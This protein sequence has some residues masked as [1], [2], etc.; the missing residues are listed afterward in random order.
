V[1]VPADCSVTGFDGIEPPLGHAQVTSV[2]V[3]TEEIGESAVAR[4]VG[5]L[6]TP[7]A[8]YRKI[9]VEADLVEGLT[10]SPPPPAR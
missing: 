1:H 4:L 3:P 6:V 5:R 7:G 10:V 9:L 8:P 2:R